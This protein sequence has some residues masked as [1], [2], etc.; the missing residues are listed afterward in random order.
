MPCRFDRA[1]LAAA[2]PSSTRAGA[3]TS[4]SSRGPTCLLISGR[5]SARH[6]GRGA[7]TLDELSEDL[8]RQPPARGAP[9][10]PR[11]FQAM[12][13]SVRGGPAADRARGRDRRVARVGV[14][15]RGVTRRSATSSS[16]PGTRKPPKRAFRRNYES[17]EGM[18]DEGT[19]VDGRGES[20]RVLC[21]LGR[22]EEAERIRRDRA[23]HRRRGRPV[24]AGAR[25]IDAGARA[26]GTRRVR[27]GRAARARGRRDARDAESPNFQGDAGWISRG[28]CA[29]PAS[30]QKPSRPPARRWRF[31][32][33]KGNRPS[34]ASTRSFLEELD[35]VG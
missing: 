21:A 10:R 35:A 13:G 8:S 25:T 4:A 32:E 18:G 7:A 2:V 27:G 11:V 3:A 29:S 34:A 6:A 23:P 17:L 16:T 9:C 28:C 15:A 14:D 30:R 22:F 20:G 33:R 12:E 26:R 19:Q 1:K 5:C 31:Y 24:V